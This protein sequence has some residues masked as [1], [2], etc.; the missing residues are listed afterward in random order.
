MNTTATRRIQFCCGHR[1]HMHES[2]CRHLHGH[3]YVAFFTAVKLDANLD[4]LGRVID[5]A[6]LKD[7]LGSWIEANWDHGFIVW[8]G[9]DEAR[10]ALAVMG[11]QQKLFFLDRNPTAENMARF[12]IDEVAPSVLEGTGVVVKQVVLWET[13]NCYAEVKR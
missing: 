5:F 10:K 2:K 1:I 11:D 12:L 6:V 3:N 8:R 9:D 4:G 13:E 7:R